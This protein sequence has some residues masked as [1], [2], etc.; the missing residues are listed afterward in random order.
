[1]RF[2]SITPVGYEQFTDENET[3][4]DIHLSKITSR[5]A[6]RNDFEGE[7]R[8]NREHMILLDRSPVA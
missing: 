1:M 7:R 4:D 2:I 5:M 3:C 6:L 8:E